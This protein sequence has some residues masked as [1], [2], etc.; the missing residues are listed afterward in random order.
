MLYLS[1]VVFNY[2]LEIAYVYYVCVCVGISAAYVYYVCVC[3]GISAMLQLAE[4][5]TSEP[6]TYGLLTKC[7]VK[8]LDIGQVLFL[9][10]RDEVEVHKLTKKERGQ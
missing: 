10:A 3:V 7:E 2:G 4:A 5:P 6:E 9:R 1:C 8:M